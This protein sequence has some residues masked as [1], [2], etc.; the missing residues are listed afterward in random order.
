M[1]EAFSSGEGADTALARFILVLRS[2]GITDPRLLDA[3]EAVPRALFLPGLRTEFLYAPALLPIPCGEEALDAASI[4]RLLIL[5]DVAPGRVVAE[6]GA[7]TGFVSGLLARLGAEVVAIERYHQLV[8]VAERA[9]RSARLSGVHHRHGDGLVRGAIERPV[10]RILLH[11]AIDVAP[12]HL[13]EALKPGG[14][15]LGFRARNGE[16][17]LTLWRK[18]P[19]GFIGESDFGPMRMTRLVSGMPRAL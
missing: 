13:F 10:D 11:G 9:I 8:K 16:T 2:K 1:A 7:G 3:F 6:I 12:Q 17:R 5:L 14:H 18:D 15:A 4:A 19:S